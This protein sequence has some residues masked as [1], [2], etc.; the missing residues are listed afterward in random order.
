MRPFELFRLVFRGIFSS[1]KCAGPLLQRFVLLSAY[2]TKGRRKLQENGPKNFGL[3]PTCSP[4]PDGRTPAAPGA[5][6]AP[7]R[8][9]VRGGPFVGPLL[10]LHPKH[11]RGGLDHGH[12]VHPNGKPQLLHRQHGDGGGGRKR[13]PALEEY[14]WCVLSHLIRN[15]AGKGQKSV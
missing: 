15:N 14:K 13:K 8:T 6:K 10:S 11:D 2:C 3:K 9:P 1:K 12:S 4:P 5:K 7:H